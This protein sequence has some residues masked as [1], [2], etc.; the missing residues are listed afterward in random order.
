MLKDRQE[1]MFAV[2]IAGRRLAL[3]RNHISFMNSQLRIDEVEGLNVVRTDTYLHGAWING[4]R[5]IAIRG[6]NNMISIDCS[7][8]FPNRDELD[9]HF[10]SAFEPIWSVVGSRLI[11]GLLSKLANNV[12]VSI[13]GISLN[14]DGV[15]IDGSWRFLWWKAKPKLFPWIDLKIFSNE[16]SLFIQSISDVRFRSEMKINDTENALILDGAIRFLFKDNNWRKL[17]TSPF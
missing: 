7:R 14:R 10:A 5:L 17:K 15:W 8:A 11:A 1:E 16:G 6:S 2:D 9:Y 4:T 12:P 13:G 3:S